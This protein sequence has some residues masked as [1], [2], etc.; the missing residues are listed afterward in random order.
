[1]L[2]IDSPLLNLPIALNRRQAVFLD[3]LGHAAQ[4]ADLAYR[5][6]CAGLTELVHKHEENRS[7]ESF[8]PV[9]LDAW[10][11]I[12]TSD[13]FGRLWKM[14][15]EAAKISAPYA[16]DFVAKR[17][18]GMRKL[19]NVTAHLPERIDHVIA[20]NSSAY[21]TLSWV[22]VVSNDP[23][24]LKSCFIRPG[25]AQGKVVAQLAIPSGDVSFLGN[26]GHVEMKAGEE[27]HSLSDVFFLLTEVVGHAESVLRSTFAYSMPSERSSSN[28]FGIAELDMRQP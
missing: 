15:P 22:T 18:E 6:L 19:R 1:M 4:V 27:K 23:I 20:H 26:T 8:A 25:I 3:G 11:F 14:Q 10:A 2:S 5:R 12:D 13:R 21:G 17:L 7:P 9:F 24:V 28:L 16:P